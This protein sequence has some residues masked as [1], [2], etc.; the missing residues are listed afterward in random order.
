MDRLQPGETDALAR[1]SNPIVMGAV[2]VLGHAVKHVFNAGFFVLLPE[3]QLDMGLS[4]SAIGALATTRNVAGGLANIPAGYLPDRFGGHW[5]QILATAIAGVGVFHLLMGTAT[6]YWLLVLA[7][8]LTAVSISF[9]H[10]PAIAALSQ[11]FAARKGLAIALHGTGGSIG[12]AVGPLAVGAM[13]GIMLWR[14][15][16]HLSAAPAFAMAA[17]VWP[18]LRGLRGRSNEL[19]SVRMYVSSVARLFRYPALVSVLGITAG[20]ASAQSAIITFLPIYLRVELGYSPLVM[21][22]FISASQVGGIVSQPV[23]GYLSDRYSRKAVLLP[24]ILSLGAAVLAIPFVG[25]GFPLLVV[26]GLMGAFAFPLMAILLAAALD[27]AGSDVP[28]TTVSL[29][30]GAAIVFS[31][32]TPALAGVL[33]DA[34]GLRAAFLLAAGVAFATAGFTALRRLSD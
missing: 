12:E 34:Y 32:V 20:F 22:A 2:L 3:L 23:M 16:L 30:F 17:V 26:V 9:W 31:A 29:V 33:A 21:S 5:R 14:T 10:P 15:V 27:V 19:T 1:E 28:A 8:A 25:P 6:A 11:R 4:N 7:S 24:S 18:S 13:L